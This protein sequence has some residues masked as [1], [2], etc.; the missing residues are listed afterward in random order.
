MPEDADDN[1]GADDVTTIKV[2]RETW[3]RLTQRKTGPG[4]TYDEIVTELLEQAEQAEEGADE[5]NPNPP[6]TAT[7]D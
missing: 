5:G 4:D 3:R 7:G 6:L 2:S 1:G